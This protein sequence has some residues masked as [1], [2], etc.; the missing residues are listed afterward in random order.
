MNNEFYFEHIYNGIIYN[1]DKFYPMIEFEIKYKENNDHL[2]NTFLFCNV[3]YKSGWFIIDANKM[4][5]SGPIILDKN[6][7]MIDVRIVDDIKFNEINGCEIESI[8]NDEKI[9]IKGQD[10]PEW[11][12]SCLM[13]SIK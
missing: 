4:I 13:K 6:K 5:L 7:I 10:I 2:E 1:K 8:S 12:I 9:M 3:N 11:M